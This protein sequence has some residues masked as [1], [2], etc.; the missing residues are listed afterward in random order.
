L[1]EVRGLSVAFG[2]G[3]GAVSAVRGLDL[4]V[5]AGETTSPGVIVYPSL[6][7]GTSILTAAALSFMSFHHRQPG[8]A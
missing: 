4:D 8:A 2:S 7:I 3:P 6:R 5:R 1:L